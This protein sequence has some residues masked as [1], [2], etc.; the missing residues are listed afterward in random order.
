MD[1]SRVCAG[2]WGEVMGKAANDAML[3][4]KTVGGGQKSTS[5]LVIRWSGF[6]ESFAI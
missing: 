2:P 6:S 5:G 3:F 4:E 1:E